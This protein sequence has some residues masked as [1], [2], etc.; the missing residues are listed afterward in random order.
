MIAVFR[1]ELNGY[2][3]SMM[4]YLFSA[5]VL[6]FAG[7]YTMVY[8]LSG[9]TAHFERVLSSI[10]FLY[11]IAV[12]ILTMRSVAAEKKQKTDQLL[13]SLPISL[14]SVVVGKYLAMLVVLL[15]PTAIM[16]LYPLIL[17]QF[18]TVLLQTAYGALAGFFLL[19]A[20]LLSIGLFVSSVTENQVAAAV[21]TLVVMLVLYFM[22]GLASY[23]STAASASLTALIIVAA[24]LCLVLYLLT[25][26]APVSIAVLAVLAGGLYLWYSQDFSAFSG[27]FSDI[28][29]QLSVFDRFDS[30]VDGVF[31][32]TAVV[33]DLSVTGVFLFL[34]VQALEKR[35]WSE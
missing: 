7:I 8:N 6:I 30:F 4:G 11:L 1:R 26:N 22:S 19:G 13:Y 25:K 9:Y 33:Y 23:V 15:V 34:S 20:C 12:P 16:G 14:S 2:F 10:S 27:L 28:M 3:K 21:I 5:F 31:D 18:G 32:L 24:V 35:R 17:S 29:N